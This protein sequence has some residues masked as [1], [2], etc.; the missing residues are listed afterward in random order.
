[1]GN[2]PHELALGNELSAH[3]A[4]GIIFLVSGVLIRFW[5]RG[6]FERVR[7]FTTGP[8][9]LVRHPLYLGSLFIVVGVL[10]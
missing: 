7:L 8:Y 4:A 9:A 1:M 5:A 2:K 3:A 6:H 10:C